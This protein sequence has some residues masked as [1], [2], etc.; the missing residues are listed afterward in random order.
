LPYPLP[1]DVHKS[2]HKAKTLKSQNDLAY[3]PAS[4]YHYIAQTITHFQSRLFFMASPDLLHP[5]SSKVT[6]EGGWL[7]DDFLLIRYIILMSSIFNNLSV[8][9][10]KRAIVIKEQIEKLEK[11]LSGIL[12]ESTKG[13][14]LAAPVAAPK[15]RTMSAAGRAKISAAQKA[16]H[17]ARRGAPALQKGAVAVPKGR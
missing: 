11:E 8:A 2:G 5:G 14:I 4:F 7:F 9:Q 1:L 3:C 17:A 15:K 10:L 13:S 12:G 6:N 16:R